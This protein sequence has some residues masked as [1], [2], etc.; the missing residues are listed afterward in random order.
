MKFLKVLFVLVCVNFFAG[1]LL[2]GETLS[3]MD[4]YKLSFRGNFP[5]SVNLY[6][7]CSVWD[8]LPV[9]WRLGGYSVL[10]MAEVDFSSVPGDT[11]RIRIL[12]FSDDVSALAF[13]LNG[14][15][16]QETSP[17]VVGDFRELAMRSGQRLFVFRYGVLRNYG[18]V[19]LERYVQS[20]PGYRSGLPQ[21]FL[22][23]PISKRVSGETSIQV[24]DFLGIPADFSMLVQGYRGDDVSWNAARSWKYVSPD[25]WRAWVLGLQRKNLN[26]SFAADTVRFD[27]GAGTFG[28]ALRLPGGRVVCVWG[29]L[30]A[31]SLQKR[32][33][34]VAR[35]VYDSPE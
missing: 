27:A 10:G 9:A 23:L 6:D 2:K 8:R 21:E 30:S 14:G 34:N 28:M 13:Y 19:E 25:S 32:F 3:E 26:V 29:F 11:L 5:V 24:R 16:V 4:L 22:S 15:L 1:C 31:E 33:E 18:R 7:S 20:F 17:V 35:S 12:E